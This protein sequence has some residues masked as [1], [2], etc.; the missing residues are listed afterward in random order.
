LAAEQPRDG[1]AEDGRLAPTCDVSAI[2]RDP[3][4][5]AE[6]RRTG[7]LDTPPEESFDRLTKLASRLLN[8]PAAFVALVDEAR[9][10]Y[11]S[12][13][14]FTEPLA[15]ARQLT[16]LTFCHYAVAGSEPLVIPDT[17]AHPVYSQVPAV[18]LLG[19]A[20]YLGIPLVTAG[21]QAVGS[22]CVIDFEPHE[23]GPSDVDI[24]RELGGS[25]SREIELR[26]ALRAAELAREEAEAAI[27]AREEIV[28]VL[29]HGLRTP[30]HA[31]RSTAAMLL[32]LPV[33]EHERAGFLRLIHRNAETLGRLVADLLDLASID[34]GGMRVEAAAVDPA[35]LVAEA[36][37][38]AAP[39]AAERS[40]DLRVEAAADLPPVLADRARIGQVLAN[41]IDGALDSTPAGGRVIVR[42]ARRDDDVLFAVSDTGQPIPPDHLP[43]LFARFPPP[44]GLGGGPSRRELAI[45]DAIV[46]AHGGAI[47]VESAAGA[48]TTF[49][50]TIPAAGAGGA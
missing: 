31:V 7:L 26:L 8:A 13:H 18:E 21:G 14:G 25:A 41:L 39:R 15:S 4:R 34:N 20:A 3:A 47:A 10:F 46:R 1:V 42:A 12:A 43:R 17:R 9:D 48:G 44:A 11:K 24:M 38:L 45:V 23:W 22:F 32:E 5:L 33:P 50:F 29:S 40:L 6:V 28:A 35:L 19:V 27:R 30:I 49:S 36:V 37:S 16:G 2:V